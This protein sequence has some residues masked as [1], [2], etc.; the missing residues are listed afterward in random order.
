MQENILTDKQ[1]TCYIQSQ[2][3]LMKLLN[4]IQ[5]LNQIL[6]DEKQNKKIDENRKKEYEK[7]IEPFK[8]F[9]QIKNDGNGYRLIDPDKMILSNVV[10]ETKV[11]DLSSLIKKKKIADKA[12]NNIDAIVNHPVMLANYSCLWDCYFVFRS[13]MRNE[14]KYSNILSD[15]VL[16]NTK[17]V[18]AFDQQKDYL[19]NI[20]YNSVEDFFRNVHKE[21]I[22]N[23]AEFISWFKNKFGD[24][25][26]NSKLVGGSMDIVFNAFG[27]NSVSDFN[28]LFEF[29]DPKEL[30]CFVDSDKYY[31]FIKRG[32][33]KKLDGPILKCLPKHWICCQFCANNLRRYCAVGAFDDFDLK[34]W[35][36]WRKLLGVE[37]KS[38]Y[39]LEII[40][41][42]CVFCRFD[43]INSWLYNLVND[44]L[45]TTNQH[46]T[47]VKNHIL[48]V[49]Q[50]KKL[51]QWILDNQEKSRQAKEEQAKQSLLNQN[52]R[53]ENKD[54]VNNSM[55]KNLDKSL[56]KAS[57]DSEFPDSEQKTTEATLVKNNNF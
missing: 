29:I 12:I 13:I 50:K 5:S 17:S 26:I 46:N 24:K 23:V 37:F 55:F 51:Y 16:E 2:D 47:G 7:T 8:N 3:Q 19:S 45:V 21:S 1:D 44:K 49:V 56:N 39:V 20:K 36:G 10:N 9:I 38:T 15:G 31:Q 52:N 25:K 54:N 30:K 43:R 33:I 18:I 4:A 53:Q 27:T 40:R 22:P 35:E 32:S 28:Q 11:I 34:T 57:T 14:N 48:S 41:D 42:I 6:D